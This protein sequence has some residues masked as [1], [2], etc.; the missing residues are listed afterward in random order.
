MANLEHLTTTPGVSRPSGPYSQATIGAGLCFVSC[1]LGVAAE[2][3]DLVSGGFDP[4]AV[5][6]LDNVAA[7]LDAA[8]SSWPQVLSSTVLL[9]DVSNG[10]AFTRHYQ[11]RFESGGP[12]PAR[13][14]YQAG[15]LAPGA[16]VGIAVI[17][18]VG[19]T[20]ES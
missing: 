2:T 20:P 14:M 11:T 15:G 6:A 9:A 13:S 17:A 1:Q 12:F 5:Q 10:A 18:S 7:I 3:G 19:A 16:L 4:Q 8:G